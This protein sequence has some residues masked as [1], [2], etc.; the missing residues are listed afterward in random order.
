MSLVWWRWEQGSEITF[1]SW[2]GSGKVLEGS[3]RLSSSA[4]SAVYIFLLLSFL[5][6]HFLLL[7]VPLSR[8][9]LSLILKGITCTPSIS[10][11]KY[12]SIKADCFFFPFLSLLLTGGGERGTGDGRVTILSEV[13]METAQHRRSRWLSS[14][15]RMGRSSASLATEDAVAR[16]LWNFTQ[17]T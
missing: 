11:I 3:G 8:S 13:S 5:F 6:E 10:S 1:T 7:L 2:Q 4:R 17:T 15:E 9:F 12:S 16:C 14:E